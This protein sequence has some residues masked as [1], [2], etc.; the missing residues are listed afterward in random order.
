MGLSFN[1]ILTNIIKPNV[2]RGT[3]KLLF[4]KR[5]IFERWQIVHAL[6]KPFC[7]K[8]T[9]AIEKQETRETSWI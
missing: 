2:L 3:Q 5:L 8:H 9:A 4:Q 1:F 6:R 7:F